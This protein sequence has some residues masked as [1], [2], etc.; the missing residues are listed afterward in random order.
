MPGMREE[1]AAA[2]R[3]RRASHSKDLRAAACSNAPHL[4][5]VFP[6]H[7]P[8]LTSP[9]ATQKNFAASEAK[10]TGACGQGASAVTIISNLQL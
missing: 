7:A 3:L 6:S 8:W 9:K 2:S 5:A 1:R 4:A 10:T